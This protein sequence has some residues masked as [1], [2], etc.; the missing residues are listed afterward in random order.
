[1]ATFGTRLIAVASLLWATALGAQVPRVGG[2]EIR[3]EV[4]EAGPV[5]F[6]HARH[7]AE[8]RLKCPA[9]HDRLFVTRAKH[10]PVTMS[11][12][13]EQRRS[14]GACHDGKQ[15]FAVEDS[16]DRCHQS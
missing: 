13:I 12:M 15:A 10:R 5:T 8:A 7:V 2:G 1:M 9:C 11:A 14:C 16:C 3:F 4:A 6:S